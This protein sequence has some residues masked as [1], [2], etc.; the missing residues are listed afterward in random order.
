MLTPA[1][2]PVDAAPRSVMW[3]I[4]RI[5]E[6]DGISKQA[7]SKA[8]AR[9]VE[10]HG[11][12]VERDGK[13]RVRAVNVAQYDHLRGQYRDPSKDQRPE[14]REGSGKISDSR[15]EAERQRAW[16]AAERERI[17]LSENKRALLRAEGITDALVSAGADIARILDRG[18]NATDDLAAAVARDGAH[19]LRVGLK[20]LFSRMRVEIADALSKV[21]TD[22]PALDQADPVEL[23]PVS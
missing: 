2:T 7:I 20:K 3:T 16:L 10:Q 22:A 6:R 21:A 23:E 13:G 8:V 18:V 17:A 9:L 4:K 19:G 11:L 1:T 12:T 5:H 14:G 15:E